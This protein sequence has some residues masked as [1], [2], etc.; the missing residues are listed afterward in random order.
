MCLAFRQIDF[1]VR[2]RQCPRFHNKKIA[3]CRYVLRN[4][5]DIGKNVLSRLEKLVNIEGVLFEVSQ[6]IR[7][8][9]YFTRAL[10]RL[11]TI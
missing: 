6:C 10:F 8:R 9:Q 4:Q 2:R 7:R 5:R 3:A 11:S 1:V